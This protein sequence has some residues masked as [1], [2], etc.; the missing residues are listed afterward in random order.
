[1]LNPADINGDFHLVIKMESGS[2]RTFDVTTLREAKRLINHFNPEKA[3]LYQFNHV[4]RDIFRE[5]IY[6]KNWPGSC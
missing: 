1:M 2:F 3:R 4:G 6:N 5:S